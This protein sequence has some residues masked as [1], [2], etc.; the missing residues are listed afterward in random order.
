MLFSATLFRHAGLDPASRDIILDSGFHRNDVDI[1][2]NQLSM[3]NGS[4]IPDKT[5][6]TGLFYTMFG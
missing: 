6:T 2:S 3:A 5:V 1:I 4:Y